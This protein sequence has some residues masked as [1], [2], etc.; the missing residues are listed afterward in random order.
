[1]TM[2]EEMHFLGLLVPVW[3]FAGSLIREAEHTLIFFCL[4]LVCVV[5]LS[6]TRVY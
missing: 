4:F 1:M 5:A 2:L 6:R 3:D